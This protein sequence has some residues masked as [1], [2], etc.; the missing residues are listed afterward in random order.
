M[1]AKDFPPIRGKSFAIKRPA[2]VC[3]DLGRIMAIKVNAIGL[4]PAG[5]WSRLGAAQAAKVP[6]PVQQQALAFSRLR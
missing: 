3:T 2:S 4:R 5:C 1:I 6:S